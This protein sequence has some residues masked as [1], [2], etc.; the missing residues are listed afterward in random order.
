MRVNWVSFK[1]VLYC[2]TGTVSILVLFE[3]LFLMFDTVLYTRYRVPLSSIPAQVLVPNPIE[4]LQHFLSS[5]F[6]TY[7]KLLILLVKT[8]FFELNL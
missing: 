7:L 8:H 6:I 2:G 5:V 4:S 3:L 1:L